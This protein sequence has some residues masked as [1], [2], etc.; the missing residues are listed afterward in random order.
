MTGPPTLVPLPYPPR[1]TLTAAQVTAMIGR[2]VERLLTQRD[3]HVTLYGQPLTGDVPAPTPGPTL[4]WPAITVSLWALRMGWHV[5][6]IDGTP[7][8]S[9]LGMAFMTVRTEQWYRVLAST[10]RLPAPTWA[11]RLGH[12]TIPFWPRTDLIR[13]LEQQGKLTTVPA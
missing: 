4:M 13:W 12:I 3:T 5:T 8:I 6:G 11:M 10:G 1:S 2:P 7:V 9:Y